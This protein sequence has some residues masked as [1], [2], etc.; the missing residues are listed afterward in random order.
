MER[1]LERPRIFPRQGETDRCFSHVQGQRRICRSSGLPCFHGSERHPSFFGW[2][3]LCLLFMSN[4]F[5]VPHAPR[6]SWLS[7][8][9]VGWHPTYVSLLGPFVR[10]S[11][12]GLFLSGGIG[13]WFRWNLN[14]SHWMFQD[15]WVCIGRRWRGEMVCLPPN[16]WY[17]GRSIGRKTEA[18]SFVGDLRTTRYRRWFA[19]IS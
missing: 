9:G 12:D 11:T 10:A 7:L 3:V 16:P 13:F 17:H 19:I 18:P 15:V 4:S 14:T 6:R 1:F 2:H 5:R 8:L